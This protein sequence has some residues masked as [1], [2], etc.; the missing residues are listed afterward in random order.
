MSIVVGRPSGVTLATS[1]E[2]E[3]A[4]QECFMYT[5]LSL[6]ETVTQ[7]RKLDLKTDSSAADIIVF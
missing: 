2:Q 3:K 4:I 6:A 5:M 1:V 7:L